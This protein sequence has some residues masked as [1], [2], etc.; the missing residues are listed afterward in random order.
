MPGRGVEVAVDVPAGEVIA[1]LGPNGA[2]KSTL[3]SVISG[4]VRPNN[5]RVVLDGRVLVDSVT[6]QWLPSH[7]RGVALLDQRS[8]L[9]PHLSVL[10]N[11]AFGPR[12]AG[13]S[14]RDADATARGWLDQ[15]DAADLAERRPGQLS[16]GQAQRVAIARALAVRP[17]VLL[18]DEPFAALDAAVTPVLRRLLR[19][20]LAQTGITAFV[21]THDI[22]DALALADRALVLDGGRVVEDGPVRSVLTRPRSA[23]AARIAGID[24]IAGVAAPHGLHTPAGDQVSGIL[25]PDCVVGEPAVA[26]FSPAAVAVHLNPPTGSPRN[27]FPVV[28][29]DLEPRGE[30]VRV[31]AAEAAEGSAGLVADLTAESAADLDLVPG[32]AVHFA[33][34]ATE[35][36]IYPAPPR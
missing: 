2:G 36:R 35:V 14:R 12:S 31:R 19:R 34:K 6:G 30:L 32:L 3:L 18:L 5:G 22:L 11:V 20:V 17:S 7:R 27:H 4:S 16:G 24:L 13:R 29:A 33:V 23:F 15:V 25:D 28:I 21:A 9:F 10:A 26:L 8:L 1:L